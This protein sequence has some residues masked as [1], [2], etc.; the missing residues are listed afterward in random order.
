MLIEK[1]I[2]QIN[3]INTFFELVVLFYITTGLTR[4]TNK[5][6]FR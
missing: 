4:K 1:N 3:K 2:K 6:H 5:Y